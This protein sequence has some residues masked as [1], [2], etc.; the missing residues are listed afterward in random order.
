MAIGVNGQFG[1]SAMPFVV[2]EAANREQEFVT[3]HPLNMGEKNVTE[4]PS[5]TL[6]SF[7]LLVISTSLKFDFEN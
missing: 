6:L 7:L 2:L 5:N 4:T 3:V 1:V